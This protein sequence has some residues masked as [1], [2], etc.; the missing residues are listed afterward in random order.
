MTQQ[1]LDEIIQLTLERFSDAYVNKVL[2]FASDQGPY[3]ARQIRNFRRR[4]RNYSR[5]GI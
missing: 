5:I 3:T 1:H 2:G 4:A